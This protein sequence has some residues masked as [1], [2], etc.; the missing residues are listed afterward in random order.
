VD[1]QQIE[2]EIRTLYAVPLEKFIEARKSLEATLRK[3]GQ[4][5]AARR[6]KGLRKPSLSAWAVNQLAR[7]HRDQV[8][9]LINMGQDLREAQRRTLAGR[10]AGSL[11]EASARRRRVLD[12]LLDAAGDVLQR[13]GHP[14]SRAQLDQIEKTLLATATDDEIRERVRLGTLEKDAPPPA[15]FGGLAEMAEG[16]GTVT[17]LPAR[18]STERSDAARAAPVREGRSLEERRREKAR[19]RA[20]EME[21]QAREAEAEARRLRQEATEAEGRA[22]SARTAAE[23]AESRASSARERADRARRDGR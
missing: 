3:E 11:Q 10:G 12:P 1:K 14:S 8:E 4:D 19:Q 23:R 6:V 15:D 16:L 21:A 13:A 7:E 2:Q 22:K 18:R 17:P 9:E 20:V 5:D